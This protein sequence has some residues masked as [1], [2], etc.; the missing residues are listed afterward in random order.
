MRALHALWSATS[1][2]LW[3]EDGERATRRRRGDPHEAR[4]PTAPRHPFAAN[5]TRLRG[6]IGALSDQSIAAEATLLLPTAAGR[7]I[8]SPSL[9]IPHSPT[10]RA[11]SRL[12]PWRVPTLRFE[13][14]RAVDALLTLSGESIPGVVVGNSVRSLARA[15]ELGLDLA[16]R[17]RLLPG[18][19]VD[20]KGGTVAR[21]L[22]APDEEDADRIRR[23]AESLPPLC[24][25]E[26]L[27]GSRDGR[28]P[29]RI[30][31]EMIPAVVDS[32]ARSALAGRRLLPAPSSRRRAPVSPAEGFVAALASEDPSIDADPEEIAKLR[33]E[34]SEWHR[35]GI[36]HTGPIRTCCR[37]VPPDDGDIWVIEFLLQSR[38]DPSL[39]VPAERVCRARGRVRVAQRAIE[40]PQERLL[41]D[42]G[43]ASRLYPDLERAL[44]A[45]R[46]ETLET[47]A[48]GAHRFLAEAA[49]L[50]EQAGFGVLVPPWWRSRKARLGLRIRARANAW[51]SGAAK[52]LL[53]LEGQCDYRY[54]VA[55]GDETLATAELR[56][57]AKL[58]VPL[59]RVR[60]QWVA[61]QCSYAT[62]M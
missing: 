34:L 57:V 39:L 28:D 26:A 46:P 31:S 2:C 20:V 49:P 25:S 35:S 38:E 14:G 56:R 23:L 18:I 13:P 15:A 55:L 9:R 4:A 29:A 50:L 37:L 40:H 51:P 16:A 42:L 24:R 27:D 61:R 11:K 58:K 59:G 12:M 7:P 21:W 48:A 30:L 36:R 53:G 19:S 52:G 32:V 22:P 6:A 5:A 60:G 10:S 54:E 62:R 1:L 3:A 43:H 41:A 45:A 17:G 44:D 33:R 47:D 8:A